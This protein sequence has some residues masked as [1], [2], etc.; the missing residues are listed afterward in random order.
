MFTDF[1]SIDYFLKYFIQKKNW[2]V[3]H[4]GFIF[5]LLALILVT[6]QATLSDSE[7]QDAYIKF[8]F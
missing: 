4:L 6:S 1:S 7:I 8:F 3:C 2:A 5:Y